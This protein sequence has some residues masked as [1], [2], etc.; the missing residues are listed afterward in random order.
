MTETD[1]LILADTTSHYRVMNIPQF[2]QAEPSYRHKTIGGYHAAKLTRYQDLID[3]HISNILEGAG[4]EA[5][6]RVLD[7]LNARYIIDG[8]GQPYLN[9]RALGNAWFVD[10]I[11]YVKGADAEMSALDG[12]DPAVT[13][14]ADESFRSVLGEVRPTAAGDTIRLTSYAPNRLTYSSTSAADAV[15]VFSEVY[16]PWGWQAYIDGEP[17]ELG[18]VNYVLRAMRIPAGKHA[19]EM[20][21]DPQSLHTTTALADTSIILIYL[22][23]LGAAGCAL[24]GFGKRR[25]RKEAGKC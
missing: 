18:R 15:A 8:S 23:L 12:L 21:F 13:A 20:V 25:D 6:M 22:G 5:D 9:D 1:K 24:T 17:V 14:V 10:G 7:M 4:S 11:D 2:W 19:I 16:F 3:R